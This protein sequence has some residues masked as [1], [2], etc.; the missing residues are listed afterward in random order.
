VELTDVM[1]VEGWRK[2]SEEIFSRFGLNGVVLD[3]NNVPVHAPVGWA[4]QICPQI[5]GGDNRVICAS[6]QQSMSKIAQ[7]RKEPVIEECD[8]GFVKF[9]VPIFVHNEFLGTVS[10]CGYLLKD[11]EVDAFYIGKLLKKEE[12]EVESLLTTLY[13]IS[14]DKLS[15]A[16]RYVHKQVGEILEANKG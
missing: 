2:L 7:E 11:S 9:V 5:K 4:N 10:G 8:L 3:K 16:V 12:R 15:E 13:R 6:A 1:T 14:Q